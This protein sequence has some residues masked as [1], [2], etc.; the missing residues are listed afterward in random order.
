VEDLPGADHFTLRIMA[1]VGLARDHRQG[2]CETP[3]EIPASGEGVAPA[4]GGCHAGVP[5]YLGRR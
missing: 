2:R 4:Q 5:G 3:G 1:A